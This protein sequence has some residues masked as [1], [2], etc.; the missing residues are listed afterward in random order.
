MDRRFFCSDGLAQSQV[1]ESPNIL[2]AVTLSQKMLAAVC[3]EHTRAAL[4]YNWI[5]ETIPDFRIFPTGLII[6]DEKICF[7][8]YEHQ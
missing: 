2:D 3:D 1:P 7:D 6:V 4:N 5:V 8:D